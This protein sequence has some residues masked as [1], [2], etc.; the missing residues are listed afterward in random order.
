VESASGYTVEIGG[1]GGRVVAQEWKSAEISVL[2]RL[3][4]CFFVTLSL[5]ACQPVCVYVCQ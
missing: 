2:A 3:I 1:D 4:V 5:V